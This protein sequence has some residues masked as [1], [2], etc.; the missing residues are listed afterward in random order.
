MFERIRHRRRSA[1]ARQRFATE[2]IEAIRGLHE[3]VWEIEAQ[4]HKQELKNRELE[5][6]TARAEV[7][8]S[9]AR[10]EL[11]NFVRDYPAAGIPIEKNGPSQPPAGN[12]TFEAEPELL[13]DLVPVMSSGRPADPEADGQSAAFGVPY[14]CFF[15]TPDGY[16]LAEVFG[17]VP[18]VGSVVDLGEH[19]RG[20]VAK[21]A[22]SPL[23]DDPRCCAYLLPIAITQE[24]ARVPEE[25]SRSP[26]LVG[27]R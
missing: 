23:P 21:T 19:V 25:S 17:T 20:V 24:E 11:R 16:E 9:V 10:L 27:S 22:R 13:D 6:H 3:R 26:T 8:A 14:L 7:E 2:T 12:A 4:L 1:N 15:P 18:T 5:R